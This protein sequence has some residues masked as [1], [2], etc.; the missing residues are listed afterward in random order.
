MGV[1]MEHVAPE[2]RLC[3]T[4]IPALRPLPLDSLCAVSTAVD[5]IDAAYGAPILLSQLASSLYGH[6]MAARSFI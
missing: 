3:A 4:V 1:L 6:K 5:G 2:W